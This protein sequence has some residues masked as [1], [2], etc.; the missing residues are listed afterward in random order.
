MNE[1]NRFVA[2]CTKGPVNT[3]DERWAV[4]DTGRNSPTM[5]VA[6]V[7]ARV[8]YREMAEKMCALME[9]DLAANPGLWP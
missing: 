1:G 7:V 8:G 6:Y 3:V 5:T 2:V 9:S 4:I